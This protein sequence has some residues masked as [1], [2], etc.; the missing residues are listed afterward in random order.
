MARKPTEYVQFKLRIRETLRR[1]IEKAASKKA[2]SANAEAVERIE[3]TFAEEEMW[4][5]RSRDME[6]REGELAQQHEEWIKERAAEEA[7]AK[8]NARDARL[9]LRLAGSDVGA[10]LLRRIVGTLVSNSDWSK[11]EAGRRKLAD[12][13]LPLIL[14]ANEMLRGDDK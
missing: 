14:N 9:V 3:H 6:E 1:K 2:I 10:D 12:Q 4:E 7:I 13:V 11:T 5:E 8:A